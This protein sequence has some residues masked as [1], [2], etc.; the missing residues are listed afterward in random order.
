MTHYCAEVCRRRRPLTSFSLL[1]SS[2]GYFQFFFSLLPVLRKIWKN[3]FMFFF[4]LPASSSP[5]MGVWPWL[6]AHFTLS[7]S[8]CLYISLNPTCICTF[9]SSFNVFFKK[10]KK[11][12]YRF[13]AASWCAFGPVLVAGRLFPALVVGVLKVMGREKKG[14]KAEGLKYK[15]IHTRLFLFVFK[16]DLINFFYFLFQMLP[17]WETVA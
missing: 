8:I 10:K 3:I 16:I 2:S 11:K 1:C 15:N 7:L 14:I 13:E 6:S 12:P 17:L 9:D 5:L 4:F